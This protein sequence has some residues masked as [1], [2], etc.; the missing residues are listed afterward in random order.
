MIEGLVLLQP[1]L[2]FSTGKTLGK[3]LFF[4]ETNPSA[5]SH[6]SFPCLTPSLDAVC[7]FLL[8]ET[9]FSLGFH[10]VTLSY[11]PDP[12]FSSSKRIPS[13]SCLILWS[14]YFSLF[15]SLSSSH[16]GIDVSWTHHAFP[17]LKHLHLLFSPPGMLPTHTSAWLSNFIEI[18][19]QIAL[20]SLLPQNQSEFFYSALFFFKEII[21]IW[22]YIVICLPI[23]FVC[24]AW[25]LTS[26]EQGLGSSCASGHP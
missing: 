20:L 26:L 19:A 21:I 18:S 14:V 24:A 8:L 6:A 7:L 16:A 1:V 15:L 3:V 25:L 5:K 4:N 9:G 17:A 10:V 23:S 22:N 13:S 2:H 12:S 11:F